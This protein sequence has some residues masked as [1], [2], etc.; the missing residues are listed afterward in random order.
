M[1]IPVRVQVL[2]SVLWPRTTTAE[3][4]AQPKLTK[5]P[6]GCFLVAGLLE[7][8]DGRPLW[9]EDYIAGYNT[10]HDYSYIFIMTG[11]T[12]QD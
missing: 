5:K 2:S 6:P 4:D 1:D 10:L 9:F 12:A 3:S 7:F 8:P 11:L